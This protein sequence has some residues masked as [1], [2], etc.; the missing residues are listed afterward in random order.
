VMP[1]PSEMKNT[2]RWGMGGPAFKGVPAP[3]AA[4]GFGADHRQF[5]RRIPG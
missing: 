3:G 2:V 4:A 5:V 1:V